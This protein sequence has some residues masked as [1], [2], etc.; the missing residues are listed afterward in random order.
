M[1]R[2]N[3]AALS[4]AMLAYFVLAGAG[5][6]LAF[7]KGDRKRGLLMLAAALVIAGNIAI[8]TIPLS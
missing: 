7:G 6:R 3:A 1:R 4:I 5:L 2:M 8:W